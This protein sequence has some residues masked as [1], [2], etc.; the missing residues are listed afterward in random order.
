MLFYAHTLPTLRAMAE[1]MR[2][3][4]TARDYPRFLPATASWLVRAIGRAC[5]PEVLAGTGGGSTVCRISSRS[6]F[7]TAWSA[8]RP[9]RR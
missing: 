9:A 6:D 7:Q 4:G 5:G 1:A 8:A 2:R 3:G